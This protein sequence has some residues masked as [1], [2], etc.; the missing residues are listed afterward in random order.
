MRKL[1]ATVSIAAASSELRLTGAVE[2]LPVP[3][4]L[5]RRVFGGVLPEVSPVR[6]PLVGNQ[7]AVVVEST[8]P[9]GKMPQEV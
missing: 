9:L 6:R 7:E 5:P 4:S 3:R 2:L 1:L 8:F